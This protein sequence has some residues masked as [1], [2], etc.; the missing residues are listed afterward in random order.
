MPM[1]IFMPHAQHF[2]TEIHSRSASNVTP[3]AAI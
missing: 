1:G 3:A 2:V